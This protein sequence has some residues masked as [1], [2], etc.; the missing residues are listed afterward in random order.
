LVDIIAYNEH[1][2][3]EQKEINYE[4]ILN[5]L[6]HDYVNWINVEISNSTEAEF[7]INQ[8]N[9][10]HL[11]IEDTLNFDHLPKIE[12]FEDYIFFTLKIL[13]LDNNLKI[14]TEHI[15][16]ILGQNYL[17]SVQQGKK[18]DVFDD[19]RSKIKSS[20]GLIRKG[21]AD[22]LFYLLI[23]IIVDK[24]LI[25]IEL[26]REEIQKIEENVFNNKK[27][28][29]IKNVARLKE[30][31][32]IVRK[33]TLP[34]KDILSK[35]ILN[36]DKFIKKTTAA[37][38]NDILDHVNHLLSSFEVH[39]EML[40][41]LLDLHHAQVNNETN[42]VMKTLTIVSTIFIPLTFIAGIYGMNFKYMPELEWKWSYPVLLLT[43][44]ATLVV[45]IILMKKKKWF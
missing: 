31:I 29:I 40:K 25:M 26:T 10:H 28:N 19:I 22:Y 20:V 6:K 41:D 30:I 38:L 36:R 5:Y 8:F 16:L 9:V 24:Y 32:N 35:L 34:L 12:I 4:K 15:S 18:G 7:I 44:L 23:D 39:R 21:S 42:K 17:L 33:N 13:T 1:N 37:Y 3:F 43:M 45:M 11:L 27:V 2:Y 14:N